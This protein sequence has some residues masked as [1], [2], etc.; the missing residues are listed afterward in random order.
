M[1]RFYLVVETITEDSGDVNKTI[2][3]GC[4]DSG[5]AA[6]DTDRPRWAWRGSEQWQLAS[7]AASAR[8]AAGLARSGLARRPHDAPAL[9]MP[10]RRIN[11]MKM[12]IPP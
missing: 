12:F 7:D 10:A 5:G 9:Y 4:D 6:A 3:I 2:K 8:A 1:N 11:E